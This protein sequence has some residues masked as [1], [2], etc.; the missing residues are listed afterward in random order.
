MPMQAQTILAPHHWGM[1]NTLKVAD[2]K[3]HQQ[4][5]TELRFAE[6]FLFDHIE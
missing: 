3:L 4:L 2:S 1:W 5:R 6:T